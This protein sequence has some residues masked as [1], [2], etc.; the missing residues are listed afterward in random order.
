M[1]VNIEEDCLVVYDGKIFDVEN[2]IFILRENSVSL[3]YTN[4][5]HN[6]AW[7]YDAM[8]DTVKNKPM[9]HGGFA[10]Q[11]MTLTGL[12]NHEGANL[13]QEVLTKEMITFKAVPISGLNNLNVIEDEPSDI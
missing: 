4:E 1:P 10:R 7:F 3:A 2:P 5:S 12:L 13:K 6:V 8:N 11:F 9:I